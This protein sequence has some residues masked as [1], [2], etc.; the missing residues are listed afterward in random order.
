[1]ERDPVCGMEVS[2]Q[3]AAAVT[4]YHGKTYYFCA[5]ACRQAFDRN[6]E[7]YLKPEKDEK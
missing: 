5:E 2:R 7:K 1:M 4:Q 3:K 6:P